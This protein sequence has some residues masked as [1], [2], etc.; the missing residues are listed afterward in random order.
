MGG[1]TDRILIAVPRYMQVGNNQH[2]SDLSLS[3]FAY[4]REMRVFVSGLGLEGQVFGLGT[5][6]QGPV[7]IPR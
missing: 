3:H 7:N 6:Y 1:R 4:I 2:Q 5:D